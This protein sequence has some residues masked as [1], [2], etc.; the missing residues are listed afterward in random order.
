[1]LNASII[2]MLTNQQFKKIDTGIYQFH[3]IYYFEIFTHLIDQSLA[4]WTFSNFPS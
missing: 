4:V 1:M 3:W 2:R